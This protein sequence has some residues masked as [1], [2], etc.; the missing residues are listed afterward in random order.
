MAFSIPVLPSPEAVHEAGGATTCG[1]T[2]VSD[3]MD[4][5]LKSPIWAKAVFKPFTI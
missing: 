3:F 1:F 4:G 2:S 5:I